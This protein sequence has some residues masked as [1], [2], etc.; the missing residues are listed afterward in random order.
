MI[1]KNDQYELEIYRDSTVYLGS[2]KKGQ[3]FK[4]WT[5]IDDNLK[6]ELERIMKQADSLLKYSE[7]LFFMTS[8]TDASNMKNISSDNEGRRFRIERRQLLYNG[9]IPERRSGEDRRSGYDRRK[10]RTSKE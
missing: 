1:I 2:R 4:K 6:V 8:N 3:A 10:L 9:H 5:E 7:E